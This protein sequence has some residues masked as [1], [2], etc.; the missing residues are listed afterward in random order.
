M[1]RW[2]AAVVVLAGIPH[3]TSRS[4]IR[5]DRS[6]HTQKRRSQHQLNYVPFRLVVQRSGEPRCVGAWQTSR[7]DIWERRSSST[8]SCTK[9]RLARRV[10]LLPPRSR[11]WCD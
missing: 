4:T 6:F 1:M 5:L 11:G 7:E 8:A 2:M 9:T 10:V 3:S